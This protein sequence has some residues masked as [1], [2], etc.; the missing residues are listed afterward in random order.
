MSEEQ[1]PSHNQEE[2]QKLHSEIVDDENRPKSL[3]DRVL[4]LY[5]NESNCSVQ[6][7]HLKY[8]QPIC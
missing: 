4:G 8:F 7:I 6:V 5:S 1:V 3:D 2:S